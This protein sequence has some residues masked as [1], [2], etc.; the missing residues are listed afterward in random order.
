MDSYR[1]RIVLVTGGN[2]GIGKAFV[3]RFVA[4]GAKVIACGR[5]EATL[6][7]LKAAHPGVEAKR[8]DGRI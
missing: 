6:Q 4:A 7:A 8:C 2:S 3:A 5:N 1:D